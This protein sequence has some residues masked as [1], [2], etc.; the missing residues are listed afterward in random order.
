M[1]LVT[2][3][4]KV[5]KQTGIKYNAATKLKNES[6][7]ICIFGAIPVNDSIYISIVNHLWEFGWVSIPT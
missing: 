2:D 5:N 3:E 4:N 6:L 1:H 7:E